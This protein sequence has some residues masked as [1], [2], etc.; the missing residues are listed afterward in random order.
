[1]AIEPK[2]EEM[3]YNGGADCSL[4]DTEGGR[5]PSE[6]KKEGKKTR[7][8]NFCPKCDKVEVTD[9]GKVVTAAPPE[10]GK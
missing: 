1:M 8:Y 2:Q 6:F 4:C 7:R 9:E 5:V 10:L 3:V